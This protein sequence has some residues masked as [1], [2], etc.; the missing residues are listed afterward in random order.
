MSVPINTGTFLKAKWPGV[1]EFFQK[2]AEGYPLQY[3][4]IFEQRGSSQAFEELVEYTGFGLASVKAE[5]AD[6]AYDYQVQGDIARFV[7][8]AYENGFIVTHEEIQDNRYPVLAQSRPI[9]LRKSMEQTREYVHANI[10]NRAGNASY[11]GP[12]GTTLL[13][14][15]HTYKT[16]YTYSNRPA[17]D[18]ALSAASIEDMILLLQ[19]VTDARGLPAML[20]QKRLIIHRDEQFNASRI[21]DSINESGGADNDIN[22][23]RAQRYIPEILV[24]QYLTSS[25]MWFIQT[26]AENGLLTLDREPINLRDENDF[27]S[28][29]AKYKAYMRFAAGYGNAQAV[30]GTTGA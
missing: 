14:T 21:L 12:D 11:T 20:Q 27:E 25:G 2:A 17:V 22:V 28:R 16:G 1:L 3:P 5:G 29:N 26:T 10:L 4:K 23:L 8:V 24:W 6:G 7:H 30:F 15:S 13:S 9:A 18:V 19:G